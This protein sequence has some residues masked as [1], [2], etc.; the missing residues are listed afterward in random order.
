MARTDP[1]YCEEGDLLIGDL[2]LGPAHDPVQFINAAADEMD[3]YIG[4]RYVLPLPLGSLDV[5]S[6]L[7]LKR[8]NAHLASGRLILSLAIASE[9]E[10]LHAY[11]EYLVREAMRDLL[12]IRDGDLLLD[13]AEEVSTGADA[14]AGPTIIN[15]DEQSG[16]DTFY[17]EFTYGSV[18]APGAKS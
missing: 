14:D 5:V 9:D 16:V 12:A 3:S 7:V 13:G 2:P 4:R 8:I 1:A 11:G 15:H 18:W 17:G 6:T 10:R